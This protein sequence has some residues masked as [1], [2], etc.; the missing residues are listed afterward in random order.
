MFVRRRRNGIGP[1]SDAPSNNAPAETLPAQIS[2]H[3]VIS[4]P[5]NRHYPIT[6]RGAYSITRA[7][8]TT[9]MALI[10]GKRKG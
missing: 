1:L 6:R 10:C 7:F 5:A 8:H 9:S 2:R 4:G 3:S